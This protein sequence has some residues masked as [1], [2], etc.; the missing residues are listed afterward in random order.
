MNLADYSWTFSGNIN[1][2]RGVGTGGAENI[3]FTVTPKNVNNP[4]TIPEPVVTTAVLP[5]LA[6]AAGRRCRV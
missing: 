2:T 1:L 5:G 3:R 4:V 6:L